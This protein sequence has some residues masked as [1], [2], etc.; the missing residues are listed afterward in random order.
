MQIIKEVQ[1][2]LGQNKIKEAQDL[3]EENKATLDYDDY[4]AY[5]GLSKE[6]NHEFDAALKEYYKIQY[7]GERISKKFYHYHLAVCLNA[8][9]NPKQALANL[10]EI[11]DYISKKDL[12]LHWQFYI[13]YS[14]L[15]DDLNAKEHLEIVCKEKK[16][17]S[18]QIRYVNLLNNLGQTKEAYELEKKLYKKY[19]NEQFLVRELAVS[20]YNLQKYD[21]SIKYFQKLDEMGQA[22]DLD[23]LNIA[24]IYIIKEQHEKAIKILSKTRM[25]DAQVQIKYAYCYAEMNNRKQAV[26]YYKKAITEE[27]KN[28]AGVIAFSEYY[29]SLGELDNATNLLKEYLSKN[30]EY[31][32][33]IN[34]EIARIESDKGNFKKAISYLEKARKVDDYPLILCDLAWN[35]KQL[36]KYKEQR[37]ILEG[38]VKIYPNDSWMVQELASCYLRLNELDKALEKYKQIDLTAP[39]ADVDGCLYEMGLLYEKLG[40][41]KTAKENF[42]KVRKNDSH[43][44]GHLVRCSIELD[45]MDEVEKWMKM[46]PIFEEMKDDPWFIEIYLD[47]L[48]SRKEY[49]KVLE[50]TEETKTR[51]PEILYLQKQSIAKYYLSKNKEDKRLEEALKM[52]KKLRKSY[53]ENMETTLMI[54]SILNKMGKGEEARK[55]LEKAKEQGRKDSII[56]REWIINYQLS[57]KEKEL[58][59]ALNHAEELYEITNKIEDYILL[60]ISQYKLKKY[61]KVLHN[62]HKIKKQ[63]NNEILEILE[64]ICYYKMGM[65]RHGMKILAPWIEKNEK[66]DFLLEFLEEKDSVQ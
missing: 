31:A 57:D 58:E 35:Y 14:I 18:Y 8:L 48:V 44:P 4:H 28:I 6:L 7:V 50:C 9:G 13:T 64:G 2:L 24:N 25:K 32:G 49:E 47:Y 62:I 5:L 45:E 26:K 39:E 37:E 46:I 56:E 41:F 38:L 3:L 1:K 60:I 11:E 33:R 23:Y 22:I 21:E 65:K 54:A 20:C 34:Y 61:K 30:K 36:G 15:G 10:V 19:S 63:N 51:I 43:V 17:F 52:C 16:D 29:Q 12:T 55:Y 66:I 59:K 27:P 53:D 42:L 40:D